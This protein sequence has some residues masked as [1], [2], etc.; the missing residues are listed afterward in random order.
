MEDFYGG[1]YRS[2]RDQNLQIIEEVDKPEKRMP[3]VAER[4]QVTLSF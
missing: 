3:K 1:P 4:V 2:R